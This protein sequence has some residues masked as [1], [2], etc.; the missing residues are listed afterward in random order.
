MCLYAVYTALDA[1]VM[2]E[3]GRI[4]V[5]GASVPT[6]SA[7]LPQRYTSRNSWHCD[8][9]AA[10]TSEYRGS[11]SISNINTCILRSLHWLLVWRRIVSKSTVLSHYMNSA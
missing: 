9:T 3:K 5:T 1:S 7:G 6:L 4:E 2:S 10:V 8:K 11:F